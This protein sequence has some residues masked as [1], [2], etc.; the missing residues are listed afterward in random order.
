MPLITEDFMKTNIDMIKDHIDTLRTFN[1]TPGQGV[2]RL[3]FSKEDRLARDYIKEE[4]KKLDLDVREDGY[5]TIFGRREGT[6][7]QA[8]AILVGSHY[9]SVRHGGPL[10]GVAGVITALEIARFFKEHAISHTHPLEFVAMNDE[11]GV[12]FGRGVAN[13]SAMAGLIKEED[14]DETRD[15]DGI[16]LREAMEDLGIQ[17][18]LGQAKRDPRSLK[19][20]FELHIEQGPILEKEKKT[21]GIVQSI[22][23]FDMY[24]VQLCGLA[25][26]AGTS[27]MKFRKDPLMAAS[28]LALALEEIVKNLGAPAVGTVGRFDVSPNASNVIP[29]LVQ[30]SMD[31][32][33]TSLGDLDIIE[34]LI[35]NK[36]QSIGDRREV[37]IEITKLQRAE[38]TLLSSQLVELLERK[39]QEM[40]YPSMRIHSGAGHDAMIMNLITPTA[41]IFV[42]SIKG[43]SHHPDEWTDLHD[44]EK[45]IEVMREAILEL[46]K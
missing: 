40:G 39:S 45:G 14:L 28:E 31:I 17:P 36:A 24:R 44:L 21:I 6:D 26:H 15:R 8:P 33:S 25:G 38:P 46:S 41:M 29:G 20:F 3:S 16:S 35:R 22:V 18:D 1:A 10:D 34:R 5:S 2:T 27:P 23:G 11:E 12:R 37:E 43:L 7:P 13:S 32:R 30:M 9:D 19:A 42:P 4:M